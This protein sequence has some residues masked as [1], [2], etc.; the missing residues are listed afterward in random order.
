MNL[1]YIR[2]SLTHNAVGEN[3]C[4]IHRCFIKHLAEDLEGLKLPQEVLSGLSFL[5][6]GFTVDYQVQSL[7]H[8]DTKLS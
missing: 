6:D 2:Y 1:N 5:E 4:L 7:V 8:M 3:K